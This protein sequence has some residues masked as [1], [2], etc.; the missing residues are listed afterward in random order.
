MT[1]A[2]PE[3]SGSLGKHLI[4]KARYSILR[5][6]EE[7]IDAGLLQADDAT[8]PDLEKTKI[9]ATPALQKIQDALDVS[10]NFLATADYRAMTVEP[11]F[12]KPDALIEKLDVFVL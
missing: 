12:G 3:I 4:R 6:V 5:K 8:D 2:I 7:L 10:L 9:G 1:A 11:L